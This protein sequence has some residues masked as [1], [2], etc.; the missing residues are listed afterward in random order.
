MSI[1][2]FTAQSAIVMDS[3]LA[4]VR[5]NAMWCDLDFILRILYGNS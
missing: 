3:R 2:E 1:A 4:A 5:A